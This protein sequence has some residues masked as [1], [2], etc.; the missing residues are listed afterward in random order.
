MLTVFRRLSV[1][2]LPYSTF[3]DNQKDME[4]EA[5]RFLNFFAGQQTRHPN[6]SFLAFCLR[7]S[8]SVWSKSVEQPGANVDFILEDFKSRLDSFCD[9]QDLDH[10][11]TWVYF[12]C[13]AASSRPSLRRF[14]T[15]HL[16]KHVDSIG[17][18]NIPL[19]LELLQRLPEDEERW[20]SRI[21]RQCEYICA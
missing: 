6:A 14:F 17:F 3:A 18:K 19:M 20:S 21:Q 2:C 1:L 11:L 15:D 10:Y 9:L 12:N 8:V 16:Q 5:L 4:R 13:A 7:Q